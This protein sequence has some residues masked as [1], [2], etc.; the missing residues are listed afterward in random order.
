[1]ISNYEGCYKIIAF[2]DLFRLRLKKPLKFKIYKFSSI[3][4]IF[5]LMM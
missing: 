1:M 5:Y 3:H 4:D 2:F